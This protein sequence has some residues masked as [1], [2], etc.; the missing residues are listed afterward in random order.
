MAENQQ[1]ETRKITSVSTMT[2]IKVV[3]VFLSLYVLYVIRD[4]VLLLLI[5]MILSAALSPLVEWLYSKVRFPRGLTVVLVYLAFIGLVVL[6]FSLLLPRLAGEVAALATTIRDFQEVHPLQGFNLKEIFSQIGL[7]N[8]L[9]NFGSSL[10]GLT[11][12]L[13]QKTLGVFSGV[14]DVISVLVISFYLVVQQDGMKEFAKSLAPAE[15]H[16]RIGNAVSKVQARLGKWLL[17][18]LSLMF[19]IFLFTYIG[20]SL[21]GVKY[22]LVLALFAGLLEIVPFIGPILSAVPAVLVA[23][24]QSPLTALL[25]VVLYTVVQQTE[26]YLLVPRIIGKSIGA[27]PLVILIALLIGFK[28]AGILGMLIAAPLVAVGTVV[29]EDYDDHRKVK[30]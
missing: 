3:A 6:A 26:N 1:A 10:A 13:F 27:N 8:A 21:L 9:E 20:L 5:S 23:L 19:S 7:S 15:Y 11:E 2:V 4:I 30:S 12:G 18:Q 25:V 16:V 17:G 14:F 28:I 22:A 29:L 24:L